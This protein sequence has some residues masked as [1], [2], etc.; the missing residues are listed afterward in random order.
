MSVKHPQHILAIKKSHVTEFLNSGK[1]VNT[2]DFNKFFETANEHLIIAR[3][4]ELEKNEDY[5]QILPYVMVA[6]TDNVSSTDSLKFLTYHR[7][8]GGGEARLHGNTSVGFGG[9][10]DLND[11]VCNENSVINLKDTI[12]TSMRREL[13]EEL[14]ISQENFGGVVMGY[15]LITYYGGEDVHKVHLAVVF[16]VT[17]KT[18]C[19]INPAIVEV[20]YAGEY[21]AAELLELSGKEVSNPFVMEAWSRLLIEE[22]DSNPSLAGTSYFH[23]PSFSLGGPLGDEA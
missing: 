23:F 9:H 16:I 1:S 20:N 8:I 15:R 6:R 4:A 7:P 11:V 14:G 17:L 5:L 2:T 19:L 18:Q 21:T 12:L 3:R 22:V 13:I 10:I